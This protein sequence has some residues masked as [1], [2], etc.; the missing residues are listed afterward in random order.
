VRLVLVEA[1][2]FARRLARR[3]LVAVVIALDAAVVAWIA[4]VSPVGSL[5]AAFAAAQGLGALT[6]L[7]LSSG[8]VAD[9]R[10]AARLVL[11]ATHPERRSAWVLGRWLTVATAAACVT[12]GTVAVAAIG[13]PGLGR[14]GAF[15][16]GAG[17]AALHVGVLAALAV[18]LS[19]G[20]GSTE[21][22]LA[23]LGL[24]LFGL[25]PPEVVGTVLAAPWLEPVTRA[26][27]SL[28]PT[29]WAL[30]RVQAWAAGAEGA[31]PV[32]AL[33]LLTQT[34]LWLAAGARAVARA[35][36]GARGL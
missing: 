18:A 30:D 36:L 17:A 5:R 10:S 7:V 2:T 26:A 12:V 1:L 28:L 23:L 11:A 21:Q 32:L 31:H 34:P 33:A 8:C 4:L 27:W 14:A 20:A 25:V 24:L 6:T 9:D 22:V 13:G 16:L 35:E 15:V 3:R 29:P 19:C